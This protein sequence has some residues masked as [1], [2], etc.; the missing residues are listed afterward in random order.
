MPAHSWK[1]T[2]FGIV[3]DGV[4]DNAA[5]I[6][7]LFA[8]VRQA[9]G[10]LIHGP[11][12][13][14][15]TSGIHAMPSHTDLIGDWRLKTIADG[16]PSRRCPLWW[17]Y[18]HPHQIGWRPLGTNEPFKTYM[19]WDVAVAPC[20]HADDRLVLA[21]RARA[22]LYRPGE[23]YY[24]R[25]QEYTAQLQPSE[26]AGIEYLIPD[27]NGLVLV[28]EA[29]PVSGTVVFERPIRFT[30]D[31]PPML[32]RIRPGNPEGLLMPRFFTHHSS[33]NIEVEAHIAFGNHATGVYACSGE[34]RN[35][36]GVH[37]FQSNGIAWSQI[38]IHGDFRG[39]PAEIKIGSHDSTVRVF[40][41]VPVQEK[42]AHVG[43]LS[44]GERVRNIQFHADLVAPGWVD[45]AIWQ[46]TQSRN[47]SLTGVIDAPNCTY[48]GGVV[49]MN[50]DLGRKIPM[51]NNALNTIITHR[52]PTTIRSIGG[53]NPY[54]PEGNFLR[55]KASSLY[56]GKEPERA[57]WCSGGRTNVF[58]VDTNRGGI[59]ANGPE[60]GGTG[61]IDNVFRGRIGVASYRGA[62]TEV[63][64]NY[65][66]ASG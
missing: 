58:V 65:T 37:G 32:G 19:D 63:N 64:R 61:A 10:G 49:A 56:E 57:V 39:A 3:H 21:D 38:D 9:G 18:F 7:A 4:T 1:T 54:V 42:G 44:I 51:R 35:F 16:A 15:C 52:A 47:C 17:G 23:V 14:V 30:S 8:Q 22:A 46:M 29:D 31:S 34:I 36:S 24:L 2:D 11:G 26:G 60:P 59:E 33:I 28:V 43:M 13:I 5:A 27:E 55:V 6:D 48:Q 53:A 25:T 62:N 12:G 45:G 40:G 20:G 41:T 50:V 66:V